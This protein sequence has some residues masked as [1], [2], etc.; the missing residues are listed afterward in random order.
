MTKSSN[1]LE[2]RELV[3][4]GLVGDKDPTPQEN[5]FLASQKPNTQ[6]LCFSPILKDPTLE[7]SST[8]GEINFQAHF[9]E[10]F[11]EISLEPSAREKIQEMSPLPQTNPSS[12]ALQRSKNGSM[13]VST[14]SFAYQPPNPTGDQLTFFSYSLHRLLRVANPIDSS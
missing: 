10:P 12:N 11:P 7:F 4:S 6:E 1:R 2:G 13:R 9:S 3:G 5:G 14:K 8:L